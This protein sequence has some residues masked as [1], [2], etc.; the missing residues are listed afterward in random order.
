MSVCT[1]EPAVLY[2]KENRDVFPVYA[3]YVEVT[4]YTGNGK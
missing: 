2:E 1:S 3:T 4:Q